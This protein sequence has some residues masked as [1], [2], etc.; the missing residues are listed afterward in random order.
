MEVSICRPVRQLLSICRPKWALICHPIQRDFS[1]N[2]LSLTSITET[3]VRKCCLAPCLYLWHDTRL[4]FFFL[5]YSVYSILDL[6]S[7][8]SFLPSLKLQV[9][10]DPSYVRDRTRSVFIQWPR[11]A[12]FFLLYYLFS[13]FWKLRAPIFLP[14]ITIFITFPLTSMNFLLTFL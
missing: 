14:L 4:L 3:Y 9:H 1:V 2:C 5:F 10:W 6:G 7:Y 8:S 11:D 13:S 12:P